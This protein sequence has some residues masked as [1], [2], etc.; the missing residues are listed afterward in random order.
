MVLSGS[1]M[2]SNSA[3]ICNRTNTEGGNKKCGL[4]PRVGWYVSSN[5]NLTRAPQRVPHK[6]VDFHITQTQRTGYRATIGGV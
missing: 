4:K 3:S 1:K 5:V 6:M 2:T